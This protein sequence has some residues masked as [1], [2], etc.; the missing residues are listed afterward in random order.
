MV[1]FRVG[2]GQILVGFGQGVVAV[3]LGSA[4]NLV[5]CIAGPDSASVRFWLG[6]GNV[7]AKVFLCFARF[8]LS[9]G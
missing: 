7:L 4:Q 5:R 3:W 9:V 6:V 1:R 2:Y 8:W